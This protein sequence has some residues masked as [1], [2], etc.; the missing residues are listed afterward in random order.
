[1]SLLVLLD[2]SYHP[3]G[4]PPLPSTV[5]NWIEVLAAALP[6]SWREVSGDRVPTS[7][8]EVVFR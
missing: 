7:W 5:L 3:P 1:M 4:Q 6:T 2:S 8:N